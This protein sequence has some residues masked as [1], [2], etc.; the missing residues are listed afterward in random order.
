MNIRN[1]TIVGHIDHGKTTL[2]DRLLELTQTIPDRQMRQL[3]LDQMD[4]ERERGITIRAKTIRMVWVSETGGSYNLNLIDTPGHVDFSYEVGRALLACEGAVLLVDAT[5][6]VQA[7]TVAHYYRCLNHQMTIIPAVNKIDLPNA[8]IEKTKATLIETFS[9]RREEIISISAKTGQGVDNLLRV[10]IERIASPK[11]RL[12]SPSRAL[13]FD[14]NFDPHRGVMATVRLFDGVITTEDQVYLL[15]SKTKAKVLELGYFGAEIEPSEKLQAGEVGY[16]ILDLKDIK[17]CRIGETIA[18]VQSPKSKVQIQPLPGYQPPQSVV[19]VDLYPLDPGDFS[20]LA[21]AIDRLSLSDAS[22]DFR[23]V[24]SLSL[25]RGFRGGF[26]GLLHVEVVIE[27]LRREF[28]LDL[29]LTEPQVE[30]RLKKNNEIFAINK[31]DDLPFDQGEVEEPL[32]KLIIYSPATYVGAVSKLCGQKQGQFLDIRQLGSRP[33]LSQSIISYRMPLRE[34]VEGFYDRLKSVSSGY[35]SFEYEPGGWQTLQVV[36]LRVL[37]NY[38]EVAA[39]SKIVP[40]NQAQTTARY[41]VERLKKI[42]PRHQFIVPIQI[43]IGKKIIARETVS[44]L[45]KDVTAPLYGGDVTRKRKLLE[46]QKRGKR[47]LKQL[48][49][50]KLPQEVFW[51]G[52]QGK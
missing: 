49:Q 42:I 4:L 29:I 12:T 21:Q 18:K 38:Q 9:F 30:L 35:A 34:M 6:G 1:F 25:G 5:R 48:G 13:V 15:G 26:L 43:A 20:L 33:G 11:Q 16:L 22:L 17:S 24:E 46:K 45:R 52:E 8:E 23:P 19:F 10:V 39:L 37:I 51:G 44:A 40:E 28:N 3:Y 14:S 36:K 2:T 47:K 7:Q 32:V 50:V 27:R 41:L 31:P